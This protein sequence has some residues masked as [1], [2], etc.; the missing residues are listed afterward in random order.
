MRNGPL[1]IGVG[2]P[3]RGDD[4]AGVLAVRRLD[5]ARSVETANCTHLIDVWDGEDDVIVIDAMMTG[6]APGT[7]QRFDPL[8]SALPTGS[9]S[10]THA[11]GLAEMVELARTLGRL[12]RRLTIYGI[13]GSSFD[14]GADPSPAVD[15]A[16]DSVVREIERRLG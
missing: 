7:V 15:A 8:V 13:E 9:F 4:G 10:S 14:H 16:I 12:P 6:V 11:F 5:N 1:V 2:N 3:A